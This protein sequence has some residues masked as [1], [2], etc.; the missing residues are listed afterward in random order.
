MSLN[1]FTD[2]EIEN[3]LKVSNNLEV[4]QDINVS[5]NISLTGTNS[6]LNLRTIKSNIPTSGAND[7]PSG[8]Y[9]DISG[10]ALLIPRG[11]TT[12]RMSIELSN[13]Y[14]VTA[15]AGMIM[16]DTDQ[17]QFVGVVDK[18]GG[19]LVWTGL[20]GVISLDQ[21]TRIEASNILDS[22]GIKFYADDLQRMIIDKNGN[23]GFGDV[24]ELVDNS[25]LSLPNG[26]DFTFYKTAN[27]K[28]LISSS[29]TT[30]TKGLVMELDSEKNAFIHNNADNGN[31][32]LGAGNL[33]IMYIDYTGN[34]GIG[35]TAPKGVLE[36]KNNV[37]ET[38]FGTS[39]WNPTLIVNGGNTSAGTNSSSIFLN[40]L[41][42]A[43]DGLA[44]M[45]HGWNIQAN[46]TSG[47][48]NNFSIK[49]NVGTVIDAV[50]RVHID[51]QG[52]VGIGTDSPRKQLHISGGS[53]L[54]ELLLT[55]NGQGES[56]N[57]G[58]RILQGSTAEFRQRE[59]GGI[60]FF[61]GG[62]SPAQRLEIMYGGNVNIGSGGVHPNAKLNVIPSAGGD[63][64]IIRGHSGGADVCHL[65]S[66]ADN[67]GCLLLRNQSNLTQVSLV[68]DE[69]GD[70]FIMGNVG[71]GTDSLLSHAK[72]HVNGTLFIGE[73]IGSAETMGGVID[74]ATTDQRTHPPGY[75]SALIGTRTYEYATSPTGAND[76]TEMLFYIGNN[77]DDY[78][79]DRFNFIGAEFR[80]NTYGKSGE[81]NSAANFR[82]PGDFTG[83]TGLF[84]KEALDYMGEQWEDETPKF[85]IKSNGNVGI[86]TDSPTSKLHITCNSV[87]GET[88]SLTGTDPDNIKLVHSNGTSGTNIGYGGIS[89]MN[90]NRLR[91]GV[92]N[93]EYMSIINGGNVGIGETVPSFKLHVNGTIGATGDITA[94]HSSDKR[95]KNNLIPIKDP[96][97]KLKKINGYT[98]VWKENEHHPNKG[99][100]IGVVAQEVEE[101]LPEITSTRENGYKAV[102]Y[103]KLT[104]FLISCIKE[105][106][107]QI[108]NQQTQI[109]SLQ[110][111]IDEL[112]A[113]IKNN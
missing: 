112:K 88:N 7:D 4:L 66:T 8:N 78:G 51:Y 93:T 40:T 96:L 35:T 91:L 58:F 79:P 86:D 68:G 50:T 16:Y 94:F 110:S 84:G 76:R 26:V 31:L 71:I 85:I 55:G 32:I 102:R 56:E 87:F 33:D 48:Y 53:G 36:V 49:Q 64:L 72:L 52:N 9:I 100:D 74:F 3:N 103:E 44:N 65:V 39:S 77:A 30:N 73:N 99:S 101:I 38:G 20:G 98:F 12:E 107:T 80:V 81:S 97:E 43:A 19:E 57:D 17:N 34:V 113:L 61:T 67:D 108:E 111:Q 41:N 63:G 59:S 13:M 14:G 11:K 70:N 29:A 15:K 104:P 28:I 42:S 105:Q 18:P 60:K 89:S 46:N 24:D 25:L 75:S 37:R 23:F 2:F 6:I 109:S 90:T 10:S 106:Q 27:P 1:S 82:Q 45:Q 22:D 21:L 92:N 47:N 69:G 95:L 62:A 54:A 5:K 83:Q